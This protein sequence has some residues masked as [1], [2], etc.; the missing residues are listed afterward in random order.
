MNY[1]SATCSNCQRRFT[2]YRSLFRKRRPR[3]CGHRCAAIGLK[4]FRP[5][6][7][8]KRVRRVQQGP[9]VRKCGT[10]GYM[11]PGLEATEH[12]TLKDIIW[13]AG[14]FEGEGY[15][16]GSGARTQQCGVGQKDRWVV[17]RFRA[18]FGGSIGERQMNGQPFYEW[19]ISGARARGFLMT[20][21]SFL[22]PRR[23]GQVQA[24]L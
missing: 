2:A 16:G 22:S 7:L 18:F 13:A 3:Y 15:V 23:Q 6:Y 12:P 17:D 4:N 11:K 1:Y 9:G 24:C 8:V 14:L 5:V 21:F 10:I 20:M 19:H